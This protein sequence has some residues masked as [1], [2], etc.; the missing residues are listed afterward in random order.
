[1]RFI[2][3]LFMPWVVFF[4]I[5][6]PVQGIFCF[7]LQLTIIGWLPAILWALFALGQFKADQKIAQAFRAEG[8]GPVQR[9]CEG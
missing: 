2:I 6:R 7:V 8:A 3:S 5:R 9:V 4:T 1:M